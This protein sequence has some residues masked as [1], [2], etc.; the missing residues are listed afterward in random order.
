M[1]VTKPVIIYEDNM[2]VVLNTMEPS[3]NLN[4]K[5]MAL[6]YYFCRE[7]VA[8][9]VVEI[10][11]VASKDNLSDR[12]TKGLDLNNFHNCFIPFISN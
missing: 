6:S 7:H 2:S 5:A 12:M 8:G 11:K 3:S 10:R 9:G 4:H 1:R